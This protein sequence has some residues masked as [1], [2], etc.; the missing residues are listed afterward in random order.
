MARPKK[1]EGEA[2][3][4]TVK[5][6]LTPAEKAKFLRIGGSGAIRRMIAECPE[7]K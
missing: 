5:I 6:R 7:K 4:V 2:K 1:P 3:T